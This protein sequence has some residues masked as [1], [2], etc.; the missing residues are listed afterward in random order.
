MMFNCLKSKRKK[1]L[2]NVG[3]TENKDVPF[4]LF[5]FMDP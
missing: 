5:K 3:N 2:R 4:F 1:M